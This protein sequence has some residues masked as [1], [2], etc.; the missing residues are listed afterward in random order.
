MSLIKNARVKLNI[1][2]ASLE[3]Q[4][5][6]LRESNRYFL[7]NKT[8]IAKIIITRPQNNILKTRHPVINSAIHKG[9]FA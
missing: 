2:T 5:K 8:S 1:N 7:Q 9:R 6:Y 3:W 4:E